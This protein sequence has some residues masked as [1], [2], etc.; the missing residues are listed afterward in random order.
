MRNQTQKK[1]KSWTPFCL[2]LLVVNLV[3]IF[4]LFWWSKPSEVSLQDHKNSLIGLGNRK[5]NERGVVN[6]VEKLSN[7]DLEFERLNQELEQLIE[8]SQKTTKERILEPILFGWIGMLL[9]QILVWFVYMI[10]TS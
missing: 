9:L 5:I 8:S 7:L 1:N 2:K 6:G 4:V 10:W 3:A